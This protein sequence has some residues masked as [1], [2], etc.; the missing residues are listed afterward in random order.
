MRPPRAVSE[1]PALLTIPRGKLTVKKVDNNGSKN[2]SLPKMV[3]G[4]N[5]SKNKFRRI[6]SPNADGV[7]VDEEQESG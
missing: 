3:Y 5:G 1:G 6:R 2:T 7:G 4:K